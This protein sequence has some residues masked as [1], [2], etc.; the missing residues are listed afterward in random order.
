MTTQN[1]QK[2]NL[3][4]LVFYVQE[5]QASIMSFSRFNACLITN[6]ISRSVLCKLWFLIW[7][8]ISVY[9]FSIHC[10]CVYSG[11]KK[12][13]ALHVYCCIVAIKRNMVCKERTHA[14]SRTFLQNPFLMRLPPSIYTSHPPINPLSLGCT[15]TYS[16]LPAGAIMKENT[17]L[18]YNNEKASCQS[19]QQYFNIKIKVIATTNVN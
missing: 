19:W 12:A 14:L 17:K 1:R 4:K 15:F 11:W 5:Q 10:I 6:G 16:H 7:P 18:T 8:F 3:K 13:F 2:S 9:C